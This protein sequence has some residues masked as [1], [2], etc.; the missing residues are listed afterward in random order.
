MLPFMKPKSIG[1]VIIH[2]MD[3]D[4]SQEPMHEEGEQ[5]PGLVMAMEDF[6]KA[7]DGKDITAMCEAFKAAFEILESAPHEEQGE[8]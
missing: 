8:E 1:A 2:K 7:F 6:K 5:D 4:G 3:K